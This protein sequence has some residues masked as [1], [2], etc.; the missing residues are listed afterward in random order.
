MSPKRPVVNAKQMIR[1]LSK[2]GFLFDRQSGSHA[3]YIKDNISITIPIHGKKDLS[4]GVLNQIL[5]DAA[6]S[7]DELRELLYPT[8]LGY[9]VRL[10]L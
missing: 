6:I 7:Y 5:D 2:K 3:I 9:N 1:V 10:M 4:I 8:S